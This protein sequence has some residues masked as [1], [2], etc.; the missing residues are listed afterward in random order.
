MHVTT[1]HIDHIYTCK[2][3]LNIKKVLIDRF[4]TIQQVLSFHQRGDS[5]WTLIKQ[6]FIHVIHK[7][8]DKVTGHKWIDKVTEKIVYTQQ[9]L[10]AS[11]ALKKTDLSK[12]VLSE[13]SMCAHINEPLNHDVVNSHW[14]A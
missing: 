5:Y 6:D 14:Q 13:Q 3:T 12:H 9:Q 10:L 2:I 8:I 7:W 1:N 4:H 11:I